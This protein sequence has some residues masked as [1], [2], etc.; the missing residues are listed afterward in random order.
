MQP[1]HMILDADGKIH[2][3]GAERIKYEWPL[4]T[5][6][7]S[8]G[9]LAL[10][11]DYPVVDIN[12]FDNIYAAVTRNFFDGRPVTHNGWEK[13]SVGRDTQG[14]YFRRCQSLQP[15]E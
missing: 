5:L 9:E 11:T 3:I 7:D 14:L 1:I 6:L 10:G 15:G 12:P 4:K 13:L 8:C 2:R